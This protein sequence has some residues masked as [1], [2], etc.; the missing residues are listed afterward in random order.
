VQSSSVIRFAPGERN[1]ARYA[2][3]QLGGSFTL[4]S[5]PGQEAG[6][7]T[8]VVG[9]DFEL[10]T[11][12]LTGDRLVEQPPTSPSDPPSGSSSTSPSDEPPTPQVN[13]GATNCVN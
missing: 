1:L 3:D 6:R 12:G 9:T 2:A 4:L 5:D 13:A 11:A 10:P 8:I 7:L